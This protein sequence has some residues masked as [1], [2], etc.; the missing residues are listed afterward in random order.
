[1]F[2]RLYIA[3]L[4]LISVLGLT[5]GQLGFEDAE[6]TQKHY[7]DCWAYINCYAEVGGAEQQKRDECL[8]ILEDKD[9]ESSVKSVK[10]DFYDLQ[11][12]AFSPLVDEFCTIES[13]E[14]KPAFEKIVK[15]VANYYMVRYH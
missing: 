9:V 5:L 15:G 4:A 10:K 14:R 11:S 13:S 12:T 7:Y 8:G 2:R 1:M 3:L 6:D